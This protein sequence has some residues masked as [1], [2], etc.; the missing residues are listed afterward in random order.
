MRRIEQHRSRVPDAFAREGSQCGRLCNCPYGEFEKVASGH[1]L[2][3][4]DR[5]TNCRGCNPE[6]AAPHTLN[7]RLVHFHIS[8]CG[9]PPWYG[10]AKFKHLP[11]V[12]MYPP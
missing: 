12:E 9:L 2:S 1:I 6:G 4:R 11:K 8:F 5:R 7:L 3:P 10:A